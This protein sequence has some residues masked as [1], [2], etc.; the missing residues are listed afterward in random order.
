MMACRAQSEFLVFAERCVHDVGGS[1]K[2]FYSI[3]AL[4]FIFIHPRTCHFRCRD[5]SFAARAKSSVCFDARS[6][7]QVFF[8]LRF[9]VEYPFQTI[10]GRWIPDGSNA[11]C[12]PKLENIFG[13]GCLPSSNLSVHIDE[14]PHK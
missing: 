12:H 6:S 14:A 11:V 5:R 3:S 1:A 4:Q 8:A 7:D 10:T 13:K 2:E 9:L